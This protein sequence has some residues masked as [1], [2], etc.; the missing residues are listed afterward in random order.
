MTKASYLYTYLCFMCWAKF[1][2]SS[3][4]LYNPMDDSPPGSSV[5]RIIQARVWSGL[6][7]PS[8]G[9]LPDPGIK[10][11]VLTS[12]A[13]AGGFFTTNAT[14]EALEWVYSYL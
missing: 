9:D 5:H 14:W 1:F 6:P 4:T 11:M 10:P 3:P 2:Q 12:P 13:L 7:C 8:P